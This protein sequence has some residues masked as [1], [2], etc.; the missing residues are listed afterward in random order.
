M[1]KTINVY[2]DTR[3]MEMTPTSNIGL[4]VKTDNE[5][6]LLR[7]KF[8]TLINGTATMLTTLKDENNELVAFPLILN[9]EANSYDLEVTEYLTTQTNFTIQ[10]EIVSGTEV[11]HSKQA[12]I[13]LDDCLNVGS[14]EMPTT[15]ENWL[16]NA[17]LVLNEMETATRETE[18]LNIEVG[19]VT[20]DSFPVTFTDKEG[21]EKTIIIYQGVNAI[22]TGATA[23]VNNEVGTP[24]VTVT[25]EGTPRERSFN[26]AFR[27]LKGD[28]GDTGDKGDPGAIKMLIVAE[29]PETGADDTIYLV[30]ITPDTSGNN[31][32]EYIYINGAWELLGKIGVQVDL[33]DYVRNTD[34]AL[35]SKGGVIKSGYNGLQVN[36]SDGKAYCDT[37][38]YSAYGN[39]EN[40]RFISKGT[41]ENVITG[42]GLVSNT[43]YAT[44]SIG[45]V[46][47][48]ANDLGTDISTSGIIRGYTRSYSGY[49]SMDNT[50]L[51]SKGTLENVLTEKIGSIDDV[52]DA[53]QGEI[54]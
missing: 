13:R 25:A 12:D 39:I 48:V 19:E 32:A 8:D 50:G 17:N 24:S 49:T 27:N 15:I 45:G 11:W 31:Y 30:P 10:L 7:F 37:Y 38:S 20:D 54:I 40:Q 6:D 2:K 34:Y 3:V 43:D 22:I 18:N 46:V 5:V 21:N 23:S 42:K 29:L 51:I 1:I 35:S 53:I 26:F 47:K 33:T 28:K 4:G 44:N 16:T 52:L 41:L 14:G 36:S 9:E